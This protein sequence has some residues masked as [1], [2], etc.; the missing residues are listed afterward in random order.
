[1]QTILVVED[2][3]V[4]QEF[5]SEAFLDTGYRVAQ[6]YTG[7]DGL[8][9]IVHHKPDLLILD[10]AIPGING[11]SLLM[12]IKKINKDLPILIVSGKIGMQS[13]PEIQLSTQVKGFF[14]KPVPLEKFLQ[15]IAD[16]LKDNNDK[17]TAKTKGWIGR[18]IQDYTI[19]ECIGRGGTGI[20]YKARKDTTDVVIKM[21]YLKPEHSPTPEEYNQNSCETVL[22]DDFEERIVRFQREGDILKKIKHPNIIGFYDNGV[23]EQDTY[24]I[25]MEYFDGESLD[26][27]LDKEKRFFL[28]ESINIV[29]QIAMG[30]QT[31]H[32]KNLIHRDLK[33]SNLLYNRENH[34]LKI[35]DFGSAR[36]IKVEQTLTQQGFVV[37]TPFYMS[38]EQCLGSSLDYR[39]DIYSLGVV[40]YQLITGILPFIKENV[41]Q[42]LFAQVY[43]PFEWPEKY[44]CLAPFPILNMVYKM[45]DKSREK[46]YQSMKE[47]L[48]ALK[49]IRNSL[50]I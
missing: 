19:I 7:E 31:A 34:L 29:E 11:R 49:E 32:E 21:L 28:A 3:P 1:M 14:Q 25:V 45:L 24:F 9:K 35:I 27:L 39:S 2:N 10:M 15:K 48:K 38:P 41:M 36:A 33:P 20:V 4:Y 23:L 8:K 50:N 13:D 22:F 46:R 17:E 44:R 37:G 47:F 43:E 30:M 18:K 16:I 5:Y 6:A 42:I 40:F 26:S 12:E